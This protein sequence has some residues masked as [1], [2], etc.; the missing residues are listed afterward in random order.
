MGGDAHADVAGERREHSTDD[1]RDHDEPV[2]GFHH[3]RHEAEK[4]TRHHDEHR[5]DAVLCAQEGEGAF[6][7]VLSD[8]AHTGFAGAL[9]AH[10]RGL[11]GHDN[12]A[13]NGQT[14]NE[15]EQ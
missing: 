14:W 1:K 3:G 5:E 2:G 6:V 9:L 10:P 4:G 8:F 15:V 13:E 7:N 12:E 11:D